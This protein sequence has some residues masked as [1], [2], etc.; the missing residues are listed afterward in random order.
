MKNAEL[1]PTQPALERGA[2][3]AFL[4]LSLLSVLASR[5]LTPNTH[6]PKR[7]QKTAHCNGPSGEIPQ[8]VGVFLPHHRPA[9]ETPVDS[10][11]KVRATAP[12]PEVTRSPSTFCG[13]VLGLLLGEEIP[14]L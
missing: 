9:S 3:P 14:R 5:A 6:P 8:D 10:G 1:R 13:P 2:H 11:V 4:Q 12:D 7:E